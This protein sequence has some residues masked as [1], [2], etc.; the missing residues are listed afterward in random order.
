MSKDFDTTLSDA[1]DLAVRAAHTAGP[2]AA[3]IR[4]GKRTMRKRVVISSTAF[5]L[6]AAVATTAFAASTS[7]SSVTPDRPPSSAVS[8]TT[9]APGT[10]IDSASATP[11]APPTQSSNAQS[12]NA[13]QGIGGVVSPSAS[14]STVRICGNGDLIVWE[15]PGRSSGAYDGDYLVFTNEGSSACAVQGYPTV[16]ITN[17]VTTFETATPALNGHL[18][19]GGSPLSSPPLVTLAPKASA[20]AMLENDPSTMN[21]CTGSGVGSMRV[22]VPDTTTEIPVGGPDTIDSDSCPA[23]EINPLVADPEAG[24]PA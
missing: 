24:P 16:K 15:G 11:T 18:G 13:S 9:S 3:R 21:N 14:S 7:N 12:S 17:G 10:P 20:M 22:T 4:R 1:I 8:S 19:D 5:V 2:S 23:M 6:L